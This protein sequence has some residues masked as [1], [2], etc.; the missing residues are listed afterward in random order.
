MKLK[1]QDTFKKSLQ[2]M[3]TEIIC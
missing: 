3:L 2:M 1:N